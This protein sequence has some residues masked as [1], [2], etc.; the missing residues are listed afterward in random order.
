MMTYDLAIGDRSYSSWSLRGW[1][2]FEKFGLP[3]NVR[4]ARLYTPAFFELLREYAPA[5]TVPATRLGGD[6]VTDS[7]AI[8]EEL[9]QRHPEAGHWPE[10]SA[11]RALARSLTAEMHSGFTAL[12]ETCPMIL[13]TAFT[14]VR[15]G[16]EVRADL[17]RIE[18]LWGFARDRFGHDG[19][20]L[21]GPYC[22]ADAFF[23]PVAARIAAYG[24]SVGAVAASYVQAHLSD[25]SFR[26]WRAMGLVEG[27]G[28]PAYDQPH[29]EV[30]WPGPV[31]MQAKTV[32]DAIAENAVCPYSGKPVTHFM[33]IDGRVFGMCNAFCRDKT[34]ADPEVWPEFMAIYQS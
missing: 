10:P 32:A 16:D 2:L 31:P 12:R 3:V 19:P 8:A 14:G 30:A 20:W 13:R 26:R 22:A 25:E 18:S 9:A 21:F 34:V 27:E 11:A 28:Q 15:I 33:K 1:L 24:L 17:D 7:L 23:A 5:H 6:V 4:Q 29:A